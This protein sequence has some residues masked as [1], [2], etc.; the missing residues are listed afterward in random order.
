MR[1][2]VDDEAT[3]QL[4]TPRRAQRALTNMPDHFSPV[5]DTTSPDQNAR[6]LTS[7]AGAHNQQVMSP[8]GSAQPS[9]PPFPTAAGPSS[10][11]GGIQFMQA[12]RLEIPTSILQ[13]FAQAASLDASMLHDLR[14]AVVELNDR[15]Q[16]R[17]NVL[18][19]ACV[20]LHSG[21]NALVDNLDRLQQGMDAHSRTLACL[22]NEN[23]SLK[24][25]I[26]STREQLSA[27][28][29]Q[30][31]AI[32]RE[33]LS[34][35]Q[36]RAEA[37]AM[38]PQQWQAQVEAH[39]VTIQNNLEAGF[40]KASSEN[41][42][43]RSRVDELEKAN[44]V[45]ERKWH[46]FQQ[47]HSTPA[48]SS[49]SGLAEVRTQV[50]G[51]CATMSGQ[52]QRLD[53]IS[54]DVADLH[55]SVSLV[56]SS[57]SQLEG[58]SA[59]IR[60][61]IKGLHQMCEHFAVY[62][63]DE[64]VVGE[65]GM[66]DY[67]AEWWDGHEHA[68]E[69][70]QGHVG[71]PPGFPD[72]PTSAPPQAQPSSSPLLGGDDPG[73][74]IGAQTQH[75][76][77]PAQA[78]PVPETS[79]SNVGI[80]HGRWKLLQDVPALKLGAGEPWEQG[81][82]LRTWF[83]QVE[84]IAGTIADS[85]GS[86]VRQ[87]FKWADDRHKQRL[88][89][90][91]QLSPPPRVLPEDSENENRLVLLLIR[92]VP[93]ELKQNVLERGDESE[94]MRAI[95]L[96]EGVL[97]T[98]QPGG[99]AEMQSLQ[100][101]VRNLK[102]VN[103]AKE[104]LSVLRRWRLARSR[105]M[106]LALP[107]VAPFEEL[108]ALGTLAL[109]LEK[110]HD[111]L[112]TMLSLLR[113]RPELIRPTSE[114]VD[115][116][117]NL[118]DQ[119]FQLLHADEQVKV[120]RGRGQDDDLDPTAK[121]GKGKDVKTSAS[122]ASESLVGATAKASACIVHQSQ[123][124]KLLS[125]LEEPGPEPSPPSDSE[126]PSEPSVTSSGEEES[127]ESIPDAGGPMWVL[128]LSLRDY[129]HWTR[130][131]QIQVCADRDFREEE[132]PNSIV[133]AVW[134]VIIH[135][136]LDVDESGTIPIAEGVCM[137]KCD[138]TVVFCEDGVAEN[139]LKLDHLTY[140]HILEAVSKADLKPQRKARACAEGDV[141]SG[142]IKS[143]VFGAYGHGPQCGVTTRTDQFPN[144]VALINRFMKQEMPGAT[145]TSF[146]VSKD[147]T[148][149]P[150][151][152]THNDPNSQNVLVV[153]NHK[154]QCNGGN[155]W[156]EHKDGDQMRQVKQNLKL[157]GVVM[158]VLRNPVQFNPTKWHG[159]TPWKG[160]R[161]ALS[162]YVI[163]NGH[164]LSAEEQ[165]RLRELQFPAY[166]AADSEAR[167]TD[168]TTESGSFG[169]HMLEGDLDE[170]L[171][172]DDIQG[173][174]CPDGPTALDAAM[175]FEENWDEYE[176]S[177]PDPEHIFSGDLSGD[178]SGTLK[179]SESVSPEVAPDVKKEPAKE[180]PGHTLDD[181]KARGTKKPHRRVQP[182]DIAQGV[183]SIDIA[184]PYKGAYDDSKY[185]L[186]GV[187]RLEDG[188]TLQF[189]QPL[190]RR[191][192]S[193]VL[194]GVQ[195]ILNE[196]SA[197]AG[198]KAP[199]RIHSDRAKEFLARRVVE[200]FQKAGIHQ[201][202]TVGHDPAANGVAERNI[203][204]LK[205]RVREFLIKGEV[206]SR[207]W[208]ILFQEAARQQ[209][210]LTLGR[211]WQGQAPYP[212][213]SVAIKI[214]NPGPLDVRSEAAIF[215]GRADKFTNGAYVEVRRNGRNAVVVTRLPAVI[216]EPERRWRT[217]ESLSG[218]LLWISS[219][220]QVRDA[221]TIR[222]L[223]IDLGLLTVEEVLKGQ[224]PLEGY[225]LAAVAAASSS[226]AAQ[227]A[228][229]HGDKIV[230]WQ[231]YHLLSYEEEQLANQVEASLLEA[232]VAPVQA[233]T[234]DL[235]GFFQGDRQQQW[236]ESLI[237]EYAKMDGV[238]REVPRSGLREY[239]NISPEAKLPREIPSKVV[240]TMK[241]SEDERANA[242]GFMEKS[243][244]CAC[245]NF[246]EGTDNNGEPWSSSNIPPEIVRC[247]VSLAAKVED[248]TLGGL[249]VEAAFLNA[250]ISGDPVVIT[251]PKIMRDLGI[252]AENTVW[253]AERNIYGLRRGPTEWERERDHKLNHAELPPGDEDKLGAL[254]LVPLNLAAG[255][256]KIV[257][258]AGVTRGACCAYVDDGLI[259]GGIEVIRR[260]TAFIQSLWAIKGQGILEKPGVGLN[261]DLVVSETLTL[262]LVRCMRFLG[263]EISV[264][265]DGLRIGQAK[266][267]AQE[268]RARGWLALK[269]AESLPVP[270]EGL[271]G[272][273]LRD[274]AFNSNM[275]LAQKE[276]GTLMWIAL[277]SRPDI[278]ACLGVA[279]TLITSRPSES[280]RLC[281]GIWRY[282]R[283][284]WEKTLHYRYGGG[285][286]NP[287]GG[288]DTADAEWTF[289]IVSDASLAPGGARSRS[290][291]ALFLGDHL[292]YWKS[293][294]QSIVA[295]SATES[296]IEATAVAIQEGIKIHAV[297][298]ELFACKIHLVANGDN[299]G[300]I[301]L[302]TRERFHEQTMRTR[303]FAIRCAY[304]RD[305]VWLHNIEVQHRGT[306]EL[307][308]DGL[309]KVLGKA[310]LATARTQL[311][312]T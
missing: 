32:T 123:A 161:T 17:S 114:G 129:I 127:A 194:C 31:F 233:E 245:G 110:R 4:H 209:R 60:E 56:E 163:R 128:D 126:D 69:M 49:V 238:L 53:A 1:C 118:L 13:Q 137:I 205:Q 286:V 207:Y 200:E 165:R 135:E 57:V 265:S 89:G 9:V 226:Q 198:G 155:L 113:T 244:I 106:A 182:S 290:G 39:I 303:H 148:F 202:S 100:A 22:M 210:D 175:P 293:Q 217:Y 258:G 275:R 7:I 270:S 42:V 136:M 312:I 130:P 143:W 34:A 140:D 231:K 144:L 78:T 166:A 43:L 37:A 64:P 304:I 267:I 98:L 180:K 139:F 178:N 174:A 167:T 59:T 222:D 307:E 306:N 263:A 309:T 164:L 28:V 96:L 68:G 203:G 120:G 213:D 251:P 229:E 173:L 21:Y 157:R 90:L 201:T 108:G 151:K 14:A 271:Q 74:H 122:G 83:K 33:Q 308:A 168:A 211:S 206:P 159:T 289:R 253:V 196:L 190:R 255:L 214:N 63:D 208:P 119:Q 145:W 124:M 235:K 30:Q 184:G 58:H 169:E 94:P 171:F 16:Y 50:D 302:I 105:A 44:Q 268:L 252:I 181:F 154:G 142:G 311:R 141:G 301:H 97:E 242:D 188:A 102:P 299:A 77:Q 24:Q 2:D 152:D 46:N 73:C 133:W 71:P 259:V 204:L 225:P 221:D 101:F 298:E 250:E 280:L 296:E 72:Q 193:D 177:L 93:A 65:P 288:D 191:F 257:D 274:N 218:D 241:P 131:A 278:A 179:P 153:L 281:K 279:S 291:V 3:D 10:P 125:G 237:A 183:L 192:W 269:G 5:T 297:L 40:R 266:Y 19:D 112:R 23:L 52:G 170:G 95:A 86:Y 189:V 285:P 36:A 67:E 121:K 248:W 138:T 295:W 91:H 310:K 76:P 287:G 249:D 117:I 160:S 111:R 147:V 81:M 85:F 146:T 35:V 41:E 273:E 239:L 256:W 220:G 185:I 104:G 88:A 243:R 79:G 8:S 25:E 294:R 186:A 262:K 195:A 224:S 149:T 92:C 305:L 212:G 264:A 172:G 277:R 240:P 232:S 11:F 187:F 109:N 18:G 20:T 70:P 162:L 66:A 150:H 82:K 156:I 62:T 158:P 26:E 176:P 47:D 27:D 254:H 107:Q 282:L 80:H 51:L 246:E 61:E 75:V 215:I 230:N 234:V 260:V 12:T 223:G 134:D 45:R 228:P 15:M 236:R 247:F 54:R 29:R 219:D 116:M 38:G 284:T 48:E 216:K 84:T 6:A 272:S 99:A 227:P 87:Q 115:M 276:A 55:A 197:V 103:S 300:A 261:K 292:V 199:V 283:S 132:N